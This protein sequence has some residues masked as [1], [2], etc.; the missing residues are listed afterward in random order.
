MLVKL[1]RYVYY[2]MA[3]FVMNHNSMGRQYYDSYSKCYLMICISFNIIAIVKLLLNKVFGICSKDTEDFIR[4][5]NGFPWILVI[6]FG[7]VYFILSN[8]INEDTYEE[9]DCKYK[10]ETDRLKNGWLI[11]IYIFLTFICLF[12]V[13]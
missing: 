5:N 2:R 4:S 6:L 8:I 3:R 13:S 10:D 1:I 12:L 7:I 9:L 11:I